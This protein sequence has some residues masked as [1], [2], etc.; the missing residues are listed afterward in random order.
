MFMPLCR[1]RRQSIN[2]GNVSQSHGN[3]RRCCSTGICSVR[4]ESINIY[5]FEKKSLGWAGASAR[6]RNFRTIRPE[7]T[8]RSP[9]SRQEGLQRR[10]A[11]PI[12]AR[13]G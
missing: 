8:K 10:L 3:V 11:V 9:D 12:A 2:C 6:N 4:V 13:A 7:A 1:A 5:S